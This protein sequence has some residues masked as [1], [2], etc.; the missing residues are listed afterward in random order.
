MKL[1]ARIYLTTLILLVIVFSILGVFIF[2][3][4]KK[5]LNQEVNE[6]MTNHLSDLYTVLEDHIQLK[7]ATVN[8]SLNLAEN[9]LNSA[10]SIN[11]LSRTIPVVSIN[12]ITK[13]EKKCMIPVWEIGGKEIYKNYDIVDLIK[14]KSVETATIFQKIEDGY[15][16]ISTNVMNSKGERAV[17]TYIPNSSEVIQAI[18]KGKTYY[19]RAYVVN[20]WY[21][22][23][24]K[25]LK[26]NGIIQ[27]ILYVGIKEKDYMFLKDVFASKIYFKTGYPFLIDKDGNFII[28]PE[29]EKNNVAQTQF[30]QKMIH[31]EDGSNYIEYIWPEST[32]GRK[33]SLY[34]KYF[35]PFES[36]ICVSIYKKDINHTIIQLFLIV[37]IGVFVAITLFI[38]SFMQILNPLIGKIRMSAEF[39]Q[40]IAGG[41]L[42]AELKIH[43]RDEIG[44]MAKALTQMQGKLKEIISEIISSANHIS[45]ASQQMDSSS[46]L[47]SQ[48]ATEQAASVEEVSATIEEFHANL[49]KNS[50]NSRQTEDIAIKA[51]SG[52]R[53][54]NN[55]TADSIKSM[56]EIAEKV[57]I[58]NDIAFQTNILALNAAV[59]A[60]RAGDYGKGFAVVASEVRKL[61]ERSRTA[62]E[63]IEQLTSSGVGVSQR[64]GQQLSELI[65]EIE[66][67]A[68]LVQ[69]ITTSS[70][71]MSAGSREVNNAI[72]QLNQISQQN[73]VTSEEMA[74]SA[75]N[76]A[77]QANMLKK[78]VGYFKI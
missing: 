66:R 9:I 50:E 26:V 38:L 40:K 16:R 12:Q 52:I 39:A 58:I 62:S 34:F 76:L 61:A 31:T 63:E 11:Q 37:I 65:P 24:Y 43:Q 30:F 73:A 41:N 7:Q 5:A 71:E 68:N 59:E 36:Y 32:E 57:S 42:N 74:S 51:S 55:S 2:Q 47:V 8:V 4:Q 6:R 35:K 17:N 13:E 72:V 53:N 23:A 33:K 18:E 49:T 28:H 77:E 60:A 45:S 20:D 64:A 15:L 44:D 27:G 78:C 75:R 54:S 67:T 22:T 1:K 14:E 10:G 21:L 70:I 48:G 46:Q 25:P 56:G 19:G 29:Q 3:T 69:E